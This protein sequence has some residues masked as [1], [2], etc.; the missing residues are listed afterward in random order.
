MG[1]LLVVGALLIGGNLIASRALS[2][3]LDG[4]RRD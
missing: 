2:G 4:V 3:G 1:K